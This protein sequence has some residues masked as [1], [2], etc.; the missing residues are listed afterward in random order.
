MKYDCE[1]VGGHVAIVHQMR[2]V[3]G[4]MIGL[5]YRQDGYA[6]A[7][8][9]DDHGFLPPGHGPDPW[10]VAVRPVHAQACR[11]YRMPELVA[12]EAPASV[13]A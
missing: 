2:R 8:F 4:Y 5:A 1:F 6:R 7:V 10:I 12:V 3:D 11:A 9:F 13:T